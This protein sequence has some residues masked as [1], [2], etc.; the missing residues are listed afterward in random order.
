VSNLKELLAELRQRKIKLWVEGERLRYG[1]PKGAL[2]PAL[3]KQVIQHKAD[4]ILFLQQAEVKGSLIQP[5]RRDADLPLSFAQQR[6]WFLDQL[7]GGGATYNMPG[8]LRIE[9]ALN[10]TAFSAS[11]NEIVR[12]HEILRT[13]FPTINGGA[14]QQIATD[15]Q[16][17]LPL[18]ELSDWSEEAR[19]QE[20][21][22]LA[23]E[24]QERPFDLANGPLLRASLLR[25]AEH[26]HILL[27]TI[28]HIVCDGWSI[29]LLINELST[30]YEAFSSGKA[31]PLP[32]LAIQYA[33]FAHWQRQ[34]LSGEVLEQQVN[35]WKQQLAGAPALLQ[36]P[37]DRPRPRIQSV[38]GKTFSFTLSKSQSDQLRAL[39][40]QVGATGTPARFTLFMTL[41]AALATLLFRYSAQEDILVGTPIANRTRAEI[42]PLVGL[43]INTLVLRTAFQ[44]DP[45]FLEVLNQVRF[46]ALEAYK[47]QDLPFELLVERLQPARTLSHS[48]FFQVMFILQ[49]TPDENLVLKELTLMPM[50]LESI[51]A[52]F[53]LT[54]NIDENDGL[55][56]MSGWWEYNCDLFDAET[57]ERMTAHFQ[58]LLAAIIANP[59]ERVSRLSLLTPIEEDQLLVTWNETDLAYPDDKCFHKLFE[60]QVEQTPN[61]VAVAFASPDDAAIMANNSPTQLTYRELNA[62]ANQLAHHLI[63]LGVGPDV[64]VGICINR[65]LEMMVGLLGILK[66]GGA[67]VPLDPHFPTERLAFMLSNSEAKV[68]VTKER[69]LTEHGLM[70][71]LPPEQQL[72]YLD[73]D[74]N[75]ISQ[76]ADT[77]PISDL[78]AMNLAY[79]IYTSGSTGKPKGVQINHQ[80][81]TNFLLS[82]QETPGLSQEDRL[83][84]VTTISFDIAALELYL[85]LI[86]GAKVV[87]VSRDV[88]SDGMQ[89]AKIV[90]ECG[91]TVMQ[92]TP[93]TWRMLLAAGWTGFE[94]LKTLCGGE[95][96]PR[97]LANELLDTGTTLWNMYGPTETTIWSTTTQID[98]ARAQRAAMSIGRP[99]ANT[100]IYI[101]DRHKKPVP[102][103]VPGDLY[104][105]GDGVARGYL[106]RPALNQER[107][108]PNP[109][110]TTEVVTTGRSTIY[111]TGDQARYLPDGHIEFLGRNDHQVKIRGFRI[112]LEEIEAVLNAHSDVRQAVVLAREDE[113]GNKRLV[114]Y[115]VGPH[116]PAP[117]PNNGRGGVNA[118]LREY[119]AKTLPAYMVPAIFVRLDAMPLT[120]NRKVNRNALAALPAPDRE[121][122]GEAF[123]APRT[124]MEERLAT[125]WRDLLGIERV[126]VHDNF[127]ELGG[128][129][130]LATQ[131][132]SRIRK[133]LSIELPLRHM[134]EYP[135][136]TELADALLAPTTQPVTT[137]AP[138]TRVSRDGHLPLSFAQQRLWFIQQ[139]EG[140][141]ATYNMPGSVR[142]IGALNMNAFEQTLNE[143]VRR[144]ESLRTTFSMSPTLEGEPIQVI[145]SPSHVALQIV[146]LEN[147]PPSPPQPAD[148]SPNTRRGGVKRVPPLV[149][150]GVRGGQE[151][152]KSLQQLMNE[153]FEPFDLEQG[154]LL[155]LTLF[156][157]GAQEHV[158]TFVMHHIISDGWSIGI[159]V[160]EFATLYEAFLQNAPSPLP[161]LAIQY[162][163][164][165]HWQQQWLP[166]V[167][168]QQLDYWQKQLAGAPSLLPN[169]PIDRPR[170]P[171]QTYAGAEIASQLPMTLSEKLKR[172]SQQEGATPFMTLLAAFNSLLYHY[173]EQKDL[174]IGTDIAGRNQAEL[175]PL[176]GFFIN[177]LAL[178]T[179][180]SGNP[181]FRELLSRVRQV[182][183]DAYAHQDVPFGKIVETLR[184]PRDLS[185]NPLVQVLFVLENYPFTEIELSDLTLKPLESDYKISRFDLALFVRETEESW[186][187]NWTYKT[188]LFDAR[189]I[190]K[191]A[192]HFETMLQ[193]IIE[194]PDARINTLTVKTKSEKKKQSVQ[195]KKRQESKLK[196]LKRRKRRA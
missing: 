109:F 182:T 77:N 157:L 137:R 3:R 119:L 135:T 1:A 38:R 19:E 46:T 158:L 30:L 126:G 82:M 181:T 134:F 87:L 84:A 51:T 36:L 22:R 28:H 115:I 180:M 166:N 70:N 167:L 20:V 96:L 136:V 86:T 83:L 105:G 25:L 174:I 144:H 16:I 183:L 170:P 52:K 95:A 112:E 74:W 72:L 26:S 62:R 17:D 191:M 192:K 53:D 117:S 140:P 40:G 139:L 92:A 173:S 169:L 13:T 196:K 54:L 146:D 43:F 99:I 48:P 42:E 103:G 122:L 9:G 24:E 31:S 172:L 148:A 176:I 75:L 111:N 37:I 186:L 142:L 47:H 41:Q 85:P 14:V 161:E 108:I 93:A 57:I 188:S 98:R 133:T 124:L 162:A 113:P 194:E 118:M 71:R 81:L 78:S 129:S 10:L 32:E 184:V 7:E 2:T 60:T 127:F 154:P 45:T 12:R 147:K 163:D 164:F 65:S 178:R 44:D 35:Y 5:T 189:T 55:G 11:F 94:Q 106:K 15:L 114:A 120:P 21:Q 130:L 89:L 66:A 49:N 156:K 88:A 110:K 101:L 195:R 185:Y 67:Y 97:D 187:I 64:F 23:V 116:P 155:R 50:E 76:E 68:L 90:T 131:V 102:I 69:L 128:H 123:V 6:L 138:I 193:R 59:F 73:T 4:L 143:I 132:V 141:S 159:L 79:C 100:Q 34:W 190:K 80:S 121:A 104:I 61:A 91:A 165:A 27:L 150:G 8:V 145:A 39:S 151:Q 125:I 29:S 179:D 160:Q 107:F 152:E 56:G 175:E 171:V 149:L 18:I 58:T 168:E 63:K 33:D 177:V 153:G